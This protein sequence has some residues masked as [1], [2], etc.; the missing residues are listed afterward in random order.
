MRKDTHQKKE[1]EKKVKKKKKKFSLFISVC[2][3]FPETSCETAR[4]RLSA[5][6]RFCTHFFFPKTLCLG[7]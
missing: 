6:I 7:F 3:S 2:V 1:E 5:F 4:A